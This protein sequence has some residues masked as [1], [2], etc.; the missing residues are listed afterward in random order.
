MTVWLTGWCFGEYFVA[1][2]LFSIF[3]GESDIRFGLGMLI[4]VTLFMLI[5]F[6]GWTV[7]F[8]NGKCILML[9][10]TF[11]KTRVCLKKLCIKCKGCLN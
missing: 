11:Q 5:W 3:S 8:S 1:R 9:D 6:C 2:M 4:F 7:G 10:R